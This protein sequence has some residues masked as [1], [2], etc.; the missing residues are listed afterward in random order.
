MTAQQALDHALHPSRPPCSQHW[1]SNGSPWTHLER[2]DAPQQVQPLLL[3]PVQL[4]LKGMGWR[5][6]EGTL[7][8]S[9]GHGVPAEQGN[10]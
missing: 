5:Q 2:V 4:Q 1:P 6:S 9:Q 3:Q 10:G 7:S 8:S